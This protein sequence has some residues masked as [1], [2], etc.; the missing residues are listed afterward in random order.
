LRTAG[1]EESATLFLVPRPCCPVSDFAEHIG[2]TVTCY[3]LIIEDRLHQQVTRELMKFMIIAEWTRIVETEL[4]TDTY[5]SYGLATV[6]YPVLEITARVEPS[7]NG[8]GY[9]LRV[10]QARKPRLKILATD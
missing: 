7:E 4:F 9:S 2:E 10:H 8:N 6:R 5:R 1:Y 3:G